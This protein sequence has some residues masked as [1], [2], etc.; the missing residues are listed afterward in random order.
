ME[1]FRGIGDRVN[2]A[3]LAALLCCLHLQPLIEG[4]PANR[5]SCSFFCLKGGD[6]SSVNQTREAPSKSLA[7]LSLCRGAL[8]AS[9]VRLAVAEEP[10][11]E[12]DLELLN[13][14]SAFLRQVLVDLNAAASGGA[15]AAASLAANSDGKEIKSCECVSLARTEALAAEAAALEVRSLL[16][17]LSLRRGRQRL[18]EGLKALLCNTEFE[19]AQDGLGFCAAV[20]L[21][22]RRRRNQQSPQELGQRQLAS[23]RTPA[24]D[25]SLQETA[26]FS[27]AA[28]DEAREELRRALACVGN[29]AAEFQTE[30]AR[31]GLAW[32]ESSGLLRC[33][34]RQVPGE[35]GPARRTLEKVSDEDGPASATPSPAKLLLLFGGLAHYRLALSVVVPALFARR[36]RTQG[37]GRETTGGSGAGCASGGPLSTNS[38]A[39]RGSWFSK[40]RLCR[41]ACLALRDL[42]VAMET[43]QPSALGTALGEGG[44]PFVSAEEEIASPS[45]AALFRAAV[46]REFCGAALLSSALHAW[47]A[48]SAAERKG[49]SSSGAFAR[50]E[51]SPLRHAQAALLDAASLGVF[52]LA[53]WRAQPLEALEALLLQG[54]TSPARPA[55]ALAETQPGPAQ[56]KEESASEAKSALSEEGQ[57]EA[58]LRAEVV[59]SVCPA[60]VSAAAV[61]FA[62]LEESAAASS[63]AF[64]QQQQQ[65]QGPQ[66]TPCFS[67]GFEKRKRQ[68]GVK[69]MKGGISEEE[70]VEASGP[71]SSPSALRVVRLAAQVLVKSAQGGVASWQ[72]NA[73]GA[74]GASL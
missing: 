29:K 9:A 46:C 47:L 68:R 1:L 37:A 54:G 40:Q 23:K 28:L 6:D 60:F 15:S 30:N 12:R 65:Q 39:G 57:S 43:L 66:Q 72:E 64:I 25:A 71:L 38:H 3:R 61:H 62:A 24:A 53:P 31:L 73:G 49:A 67:E 51:A 4:S 32:E 48:E 33:A 69:T 42:E 36:R 35:E 41:R 58:L 52:V 14:Q 10:L 22:L 21:K 50:G 16:A 63:N 26:F 13:Q 11:S 56:T 45:S 44:V 18:D 55:L 27:E 74:F 34:S 8:A 70:A 17:A 59:A 19:D 5:R 20:A 2:E 7:G